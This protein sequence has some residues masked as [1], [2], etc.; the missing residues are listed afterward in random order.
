MQRIRDLLKPENIITGVSIRDIR[1]PTSFEFHGSDA[2][3]KDPDYSAA[4][5]IITVEGIEYKGHGL[6]FTIGRGTE[7]VCS[8]ITALLPLVIGKS[9]LDIYTDFA[10]FW[11]SITCESQL[12]WIGPEKGA[13]HLAVAAVVN[14]LW[15]LWGKLEG[16]PVWKLLCDMSPEEIMSLI[17][18]QYLSDALTKEEALEILRNKQSTHLERIDEITKNGYPA[19]IT[20]AGWLGYSDDVVKERL[21]EAMSLGFRKFKMK[22]GRDL[23]LDKHR[24]ALIRSEIGYDVPLMMDANQCWDVDEAIKHMT[25]LAEYKPLWI[26]EPTSPDDILGHA[27]IGK[28]LRPFGIGIATG[29]HCHNR[30][31][32]KQFLEAGS[33]DFCQIDS[34]RLGGVNEIL[35]VLLLAERFNV[36]VCPH[37]GGVGLCEFA[38]HLIIF[39]Y[40]CISG[41]KD[42]RMIEY[43]DHLHE[44]F[45]NPVVVQ[46]GSYIVPTTPG[47]SS[48]MKE[49]S[50]NKF[51]FPDGPVWTSLRATN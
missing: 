49:E 21:K 30:V 3:H 28:A 40:I 6:T 35:A 20:S 42:R 1:F 12:R 43:A 13:V 4:Y 38:Q 11:H 41:T 16:K 19:Y 46:N 31:M 23:Q 27:K 14:A 34:C 22:V 50:L 5:V 33:M 26:E 18:W 32:F 7:V 39:Y 36:P 17:D 44:H 15:D 25:G 9:V 47:Y 51:E 24:C 37:A 2:L 29:E 48:E 8:A 45:V 10:T